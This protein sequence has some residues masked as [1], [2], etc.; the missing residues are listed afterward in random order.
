MDASCLCWSLP[1]ASAHLA[2][3]AKKANRALRELLARKVLVV[4]RG[5]PEPKGRSAR[6]A[7]RAIKEMQGRKE[8]RVLKARAVSKVHPDRL[9]ETRGHRERVA[10]QAFG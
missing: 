2:P 1:G 9:V 5:H 4:N 3:K 8:W 10:R 6:R 7:R